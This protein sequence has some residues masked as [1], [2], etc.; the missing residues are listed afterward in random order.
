VGGVGEGGTGT[1]YGTN[2]FS[3]HLDNFELPA[4]DRHVIRTWLRRWLGLEESAKSSAVPRTGLELRVLELEQHVDWLHGA[5]RK[6]RGRV[7]GSIRNHAAPAGEEEGPVSDAPPL[8]IS[9]G[10]ERQWELASLAK[11]RAEEMG[12]AMKGGG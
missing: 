7:T 1:L 2:H 6:L 12:R 4:K 3:T 5:L 10:I 8:S 11:T 9:S